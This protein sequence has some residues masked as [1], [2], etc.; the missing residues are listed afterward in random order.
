MVAYIQLRERARILRRQGK[1]IRGISQV[2]RASKST[3][4]YW[5]R[6][7]ELSDK[8]IRLLAKS[9][10]EGAGLG[11]LR[12]AE[13]KR[14]ERIS[15]TRT[16]FE[17]GK[18][19]VG[20]LS[21]RDIFILGA[22]LYWGEG[23]K[24]GNEECGLTNSSPDIIQAFIVW[25]REIHSV[26]SRDLILRVSINHSHKQ[27]IRAVEKYWSSMTKIPLSQFTKA[28]FIKTKSQKIYANPYEHFGTIRVKVRRATA[29]RR[30]ILGSIAE[31]ARQICET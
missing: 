26:E 12:A 30:R 21:R 27:R 1:S 16:E 9:Q 6:D 7:I 22:A 24:S 15:A 23:Y 17:H 31:I 13:M 14:A 2:L 11:R 5:C 4:S 3:V 28:S 18:R 19:S 25:L 10:R 20:L 29:L 8:Q